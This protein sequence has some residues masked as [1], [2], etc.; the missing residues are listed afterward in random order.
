MDQLDGDNDL[1]LNGDELDGHL[2]ED[3]FL[4]HG[5]NWIGYPGCPIADPGEDNQDKEMA[6][7]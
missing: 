5:A 6:H 7:D 4:Y 3:E 1:E 2:G